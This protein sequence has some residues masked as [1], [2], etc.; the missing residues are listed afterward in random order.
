MSDDKLTVKDLGLAPLNDMEANTWE[1]EP[2]LGVGDTSKCLPSWLVE[3]AKRIKLNADWVMSPTTIRSIAH[4]LA[5]ARVRNARLAR[6]RDEA[7]AEN[8]RLRA[9][10]EKFANEKNWMEMSDVDVGLSIEFGHAWK[11]VGQAWKADEHYDQ[12]WQIAQE[13]LKGREETE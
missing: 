7:L 4:T 10:L 1:A 13:A 5:G 8:A 9:A 12:P 6:Q 11:E 2:Y 3:F